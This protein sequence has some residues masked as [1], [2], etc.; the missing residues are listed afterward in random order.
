M[1]TDRAALY[2]QERLV[3]VMWF[4]M[5]PKFYAFTS[6]SNVKTVHSI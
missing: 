5:H 6:P 2:I 1:L 4:L 3:G